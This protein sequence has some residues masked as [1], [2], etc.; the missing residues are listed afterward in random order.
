MPDGDAKL[1]GGRVSVFEVPTSSPEVDGTFAWNKTVMV[2]AELEAGGEAGL[3]YTY[4]N[5]ATAVQAE[6]LIKEVLIGRSAFDIPCAWQAMVA[7]VRN[8]GRP[9]IASMAIS[10]LDCAL[11]DLK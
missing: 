9:G 11:W 7:A 6:E 1:T 8:M 5:R 3:G 2:L 4:A 10:A